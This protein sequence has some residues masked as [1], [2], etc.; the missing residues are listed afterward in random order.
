MDLPSRQCKVKVKDRSLIQTNDNETEATAP[1]SLQSALEDAMSGLSG[2]D[3]HPGRSPRPRAFVRPSGTENVVRVY[4]EASTQ[5]DADL[6]ASEA[7]GL[8]YKLCHGIGDIPNFVARRS[9]L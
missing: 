4:A 5:K 2:K 6:L 7:A 8:V 1:T 9:N 3:L